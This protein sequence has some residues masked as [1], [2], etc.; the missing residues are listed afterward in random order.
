[1]RKVRREVDSG[2]SF[3][4]DGRP[5]GRPPGSPGRLEHPG[6][7]VSCPS[8]GGQ[9]PQLLVVR[10][11]A[12]SGREPAFS[13]GAVPHVAHLLFGGEQ[14]PY[15]TKPRLDPPCSSKSARTPSNPCS[16]ISSICAQS[17]HTT[18]TWSCFGTRPLTRGGR[19]GKPRG[20][21]RR[22]ETGRP[23]SHFPASRP[24]RRRGLAVRSARQDG[25]SVLLPQGRHA[26]FLS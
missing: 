1:V 6:V 21:A 7:S 24:G 19:D 17:Q 2:V 10:F 22:G 14:L 9:S 4:S 13:D 20:P 23:S 15:D 16:E 25:G 26:G 11:V 18:G 3:R 5:L 8:F 12:S